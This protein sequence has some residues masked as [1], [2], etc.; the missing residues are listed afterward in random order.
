MMAAQ[1]HTAWAG[2]LL[3]NEPMSRHTTWRVGGPARRYYRP[4]SI[5]DLAVFMQSLPE[6]EP[7]V[8]IGLG[9]NLLVRDGG[10]AATVIATSGAL[11]SIRILSGQRIYVECGSSCAKVARFAA[12]HGLA[13]AEFLSG[14]PGTMGGALAMNAGCFGGETWQRVSRVQTLDRHGVLRW[15]EPSDY[16][17][18]YRH[19][20]GPEDEWFVAAELQLEQGDAQALQQANRALLD[21]R[22][23]SQPTRWPS[24]GSVF[25][26]P[27]GDYAARLIDSAG[28]KGLRLGGALVSEQHA[29]FIVNAGEASAADIEALIRRVQDEVERVHG[30][31][32]QTEVCVIGEE[33]P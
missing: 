7:I 23:A 3:E 1:Q 28:L 25:R 10:I 13:G 12:R 26:N 14:I 5:D 20:R 15:R 19:V 8:W 18:A 21:K 32:L 16:A 31:R 22:G 33:A 11:D 27:E 4:L 24:A 9:S 2:E 6:Q 30:L 17:V 29:N